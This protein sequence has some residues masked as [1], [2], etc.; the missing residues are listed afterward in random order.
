RRQHLAMLARFAFARQDHDE[1]LRLQQECLTLTD[2]TTDA[3]E[4]GLLFYSLGNTHLAK[5]DWAAA[6]TAYGQAIQIALDQD[7]DG[8]LPMALTN[9]G[10]SLHR[11]GR[12]TEAVQSFAVARKTWQAQNHP[13]GQAYTL[14]ALAQVYQAE[15][16]N[17]EAE[18]CWLEAIALVEGIGRDAVQEPFQPGRAA[19]VQKLVQHY[20]ATNQA[21]KLERLR[22]S[23]GG[24]AR[25]QSDRAN[26]GS[27]RPASGSVGTT[28]PPTRAA[29]PVAA[30]D[31]ARCRNAGSGEDRPGP[32]ASPGPGWEPPEP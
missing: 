25:G 30:G 7:I 12:M 20:Q 3:A 29:G 2:P 18:A 5:R 6:E 1:T 11:Q 32:V 17:A 16:K 9:L 14:D 24:P 26:P 23:P 31:R 28:C 27:G 13:P 22:R 8:F 21:S 19:L 10:V 15:K 4:A